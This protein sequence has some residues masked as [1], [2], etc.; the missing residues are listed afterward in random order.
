MQCSSEKNRKY[1]AY[2]NAKQSHNDVVAYFKEKSFTLF[3]NNF[4]WKQFL[5]Y[6]LKN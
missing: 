1:Y 5:C 4:N 2:L 6:N 3:I